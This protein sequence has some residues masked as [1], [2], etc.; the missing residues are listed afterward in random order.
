V[1]SRTPQLIAQLG[2]GATPR[3]SRRSVLCEAPLELVPEPFRQ[4]LR[5]SITHI[6]VQQR[7][8]EFAPLVDRELV[9]EIDDSPNAVGGRHGEKMP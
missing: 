7:D 3:L 4:R 5:L 6:V 2:K 1:R 9:C 8:L